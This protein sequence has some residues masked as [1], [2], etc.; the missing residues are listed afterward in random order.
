MKAPHVAE[1]YRPG[2]RFRTTF[3]VWSNGTPVPENIFAR[4]KADGYQLRPARPDEIFDDAD[5]IRVAPLP[6]AP[7]VAVIKTGA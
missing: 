4:L 2:H 1:G 7:G 5:M 6:A 3:G